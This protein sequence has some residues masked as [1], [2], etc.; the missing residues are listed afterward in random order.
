M[1]NMKENFHYYL[2]HQEE[3]V[4][5]YDGRVLVIRDKKVVGDFKDNDEAYTF[6]MINYGGGN[7]LMQRCSPG[8]RDYTISIAPRCRR[9]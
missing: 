2:D 1:I 8:K 3:L 5:Q 7:F 4:Q 9:V 6:G